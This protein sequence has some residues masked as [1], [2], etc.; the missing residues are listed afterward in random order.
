MKIAIYNGNLN[1][2]TFVW[3]LAK[4]VN[5][6]HD[7]LVC[8]TSSK[9]YKFKNSGINFLPTDSNYN[10]VLLVQFVSKLVSFSCLYPK[11]S[12]C[13]I[14]ILWHSKKPFKTRIKQFLIWSKFIS[15]KIDV[16]HVQWASHISLFEEILDVS[17]FKM[18][19]SLRG[20]LI[21]IAPLSNP[22]ME[23]LYQST[24]K[25]IDQFHAVSLDIKK[26]ALTY[27]VAQDKIKV[28]YS[29]IN[30]SSFELFKKVNYV[31]SE[32]LKILSVGRTHWNKGYNYALDAFKSFSDHHINATYTIIG[33]ADSEEIIYSIHDLN[34]EQKVILTPKTKYNEVLKAMQRADVLILPSVSEGLANVVIE[35]MMIGLPVIS[36]NVGGMPELVIHHETGLLF[37]NR[38]VNDLAKKMMEFNSMSSNDVRIMAENAFQ[39]V[40]EQHSWIGFKQGFS[41]FYNS[42]YS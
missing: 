38:D 33:A 18:M 13:F 9:L 41:N 17:Y 42:E 34:M 29:G 4:V 1:L 23:S 12:R 11:K 37:E 6:D 39:K 10:L 35:A 3:R 8:G 16:V 22:N 30:C 7:V 14:S 25:K 28:V 27:G 19:I 31:R 21:N 40:S 5:E 2:T 26:K 36:T 24:F 20:S 32:N 15:N